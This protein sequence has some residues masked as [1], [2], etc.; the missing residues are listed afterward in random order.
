M[1]FGTCYDLYVV[2]AL[3]IEAEFLKQNQLQQIALDTLEN[4]EKIPKIV[5]PQGEFL[6]KNKKKFLFRIFYYIYNVVFC[7]PEYGI[8]Y[9]Y[10]H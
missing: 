8:Y 3:D 10:F 5:Q 7:S 2:R 6:L 9:G 4:S 1:L